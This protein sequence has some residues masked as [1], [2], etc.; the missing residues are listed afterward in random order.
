MHIVF[1]ESEVSLKWYEQCADLV[2]NEKNGQLAN[3]GFLGGTA[4]THLNDEGYSQ[5]GAREARVRK[6][7][8][9]VG[10]ADGSANRGDHSRF[11]PFG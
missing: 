1:I 3:A 10:E 6:A 5:Y 9:A 4:G 2:R 8:D 11:H 7:E